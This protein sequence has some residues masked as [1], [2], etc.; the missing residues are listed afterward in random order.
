MSTIVS[1]DID[2]NHFKGNAPEYVTVEGAAISD[3]SAPIDDTEWTVILEKI[4]VQPHKL[5]SFKRE[6]KATGP[7]N[8]IR[9]TIAPDGGISRVRILGQRVIQKPYEITSNDKN[10]TTNAKN[11]NDNANNVE[12]SPNDTIEN[13]TTENDV[14][15]NLDNDI[16]QQENSE[17]N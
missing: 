10:E 9:I 2:T 16:N 8:C 11:E 15:K 4:K 17:S 5:Q 3:L 12:S 1:V 13:N 14:D 7:F 6:I